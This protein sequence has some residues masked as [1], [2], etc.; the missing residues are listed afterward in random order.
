MLSGHSGPVVTIA[1]LYGA[2]GSVAGRR[3]AERLGVP[4]FDREIPNAVAKRAGISADAVADI[5]GAP[6]SG[7][8]GFISRVAR[9]ATPSGAPGGYT[10][11][12]DVQES[13]LRGYIEGFLPRVS[14]SGGVVLGR[15]GMIVLCDVP[16]ALRGSREARVIQGMTIEGIEHRHLKDSAGSNGPCS[17]VPAGCYR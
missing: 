14:V 11:H 9:A 3:V 16:S 7:M 13:R 8:T 1:A 2:G 15:G 4:F 6:R 12:P 17:S 5:D 10:V